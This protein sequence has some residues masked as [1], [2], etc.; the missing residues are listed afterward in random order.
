MKYGVE[1]AIAAIIIIL[2]IFVIGF[3]FRKKYYKEVDRLEAMKLELMN[4][5]VMDEMLKVKNLNMAGQTEEM[6]E[7]WR[8]MWDDITTVQ[9]P[10]VDEKLFYAE[11]FIDKYRF[12][13]TKDIL[14]KT[15]HMIIEIEGQIEI[16]LAELAELMDCE[17]SN[18]TVI[19][20]K[21]EQYLE[22][23]KNLLAYRHQYG[24][25]ADKL[26]AIFQSIQEQLEEYDSLVDQGN[27]LQAREIV[28]NVSEEIEQVAVKMEKIPDLLVECMTILPS[29]RQELDA[30]Y[31]EMIQQG[32][33]LE[34]LEIEKQFER[35]DQNLEAYEQFLKNA[36]VQEVENGIEEL[37]EK[38]DSLYD[39]FEKEVYAKHYVK[40]ENGKT[41]E[42]IENLKRTNDEIREETSI[43][44]HSYQLLDEDLHVPNIFED[45]LSKLTQSYERLNAKITEE[46]TAFTLLSDELQQLESQITALESE[47]NEFIEK[48]QN[49][50]KDEWEVREKTTALQRKVQD[51]IRIVQ[52]SRLPGLP[53]DIESLFEQAEEQIEDIYKSLN[54]KPLNMKSVHKY[55]HDATDTVNHLFNR[56]ED[57]IEHAQFAERVIQYGNRY[58]RHDESLRSSLEKA[59]QS[60][61]RYEYKA[62][63]EQAATAVEE[64]EPGALKKIE[65]MMNQE[66]VKQ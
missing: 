10:N 62:A 35:L 27:Y 57:H 33:I 1:I 29:Q 8:S 50:R 3:I 42:W 49:L 25:A 22:L 23:K 55:L 43:V 6:F 11:E 40:N 46:T 61:R 36:E 18:R 51:T 32:Y 47:Q 48:L 41:E 26:D 34:H 31:K 2:I 9:L 44:K 56:T 21:S 39:L 58:R 52:K 14:E 63:L 45:Q 15:E 53:A 64:V 65:D 17:E 16:I 54:A 7:K 24:I 28:K 13:Q 4:S 12:R 60:F 30:G 38:I 37:K 66:L 5:V 20:E 59:E 19:A